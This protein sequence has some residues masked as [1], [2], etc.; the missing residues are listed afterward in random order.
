MD[1]DYMGLGLGA[2][3]GQWVVFS[4]GIPI[5]GGGAA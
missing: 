2:G 1:L 5:H 3:H 4:G